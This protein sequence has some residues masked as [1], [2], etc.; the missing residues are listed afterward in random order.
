MSVF[1]HPKQASR[2]LI[3]VGSVLLGLCARFSQDAETVLPL[4]G[5]YIGFVMLIRGLWLGWKTRRMD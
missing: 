5:A 3:A 2:A 1:N 4:I